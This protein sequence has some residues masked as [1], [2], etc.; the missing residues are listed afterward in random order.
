MFYSAVVDYVKINKN[1][2]ADKRNAVGI[3]TEDLHSF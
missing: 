2:T 3:I 1:V